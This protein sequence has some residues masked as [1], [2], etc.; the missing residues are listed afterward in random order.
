MRLLF[1]I[2]SL[3]LQALLVNGH[4]RL[5][6]PP[7]RNAMW[8]FG[9]P[10]PVDY[11]DNE[12]YCG[13][14]SIHWS[15]N[16]GKCGVCGDRWDEPPPRLHESGGFY[17]TGLLGKRY[18]PGQII[19][20]EVELTAN[21]K[22]HFELRLCP[23]SG[24]PTLAEKQDCFNKYPLYLEGSTSHRFQIPE[25][26]KRQETFKYRVKLPDG[27]TCTRCVIQWIYFT[28]NTW[29]LCENGVGAVGCGN[30]ETFKNCADVAIITNTGGFGPA[31]VVPSA[32]T[33][34]QD[35]PYAI[36][37]LNMTKKGV[38]EQT[39][40]VR[41]QVCIANENFKDKNRFDSW[42]MANCLKYPPTCPENVCT[43]LTECVPT[44]E[45]AKQP[46]AD[47]HC[48]INCLRFPPSERCPE[49]CKCT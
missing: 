45:Y 19:D 9:F 43:C 34:L 46:G 35:N 15:L 49:W 2:A 27:V 18:T 39:L 22:G 29:D 40:V 44:G 8:R 23:L 3:L 30:Q 14:F 25:D 11:Q 31:G 38:Q 10:N 28:G 42:C 20:I 13:G 37:L 24:D 36:K 21:H 5:M 47:V 32:P 12:L 26:T 6:D 17:D 1:T 4:G 41:S 33:S 48:H 16:G 7:A